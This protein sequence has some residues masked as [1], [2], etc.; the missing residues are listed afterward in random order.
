MIDHSDRN[1]GVGSMDYPGETYIA[2]APDGLQISAYR[3]GPNYGVPVLLIGG[4][5]S[6]MQ[7]VFVSERELDEIS[8]RLFSF[9]RRGYGKT[10]YTPDGYVEDVV[11]DAVA[12]LEGVQKFG[13]VA[14][15]GGVRS[16]LMISATL[17]ERVSGMVLMGGAAPPDLDIDPLEG[18]SDQ[19]KI[20]LT[21]AAQ[22]PEAAER[23]M[24]ARAR[25][26]SEDAGYWYDEVLSPSFRRADMASGVVCGLRSRTIRGHATSLGDG[27]GWLNDLLMGQKP[28]MRQGQLDLAG[29]TAPT[30]LLHG[31]ED[32][33]VSSEN[34]KLL[35]E[36]IPNAI[37]HILEGESHM[38]LPSYTYWSLET[39]RDLH[40]GSVASRA[41][42][43]AEQKWKEMRESFMQMNPEPFLWR[44][45]S[46]SFRE[47][48]FITK[49]FG[50][51]Y[52][53]ESNQG[54][55]IG[56]TFFGCIALI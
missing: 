49:L 27:S 3:M 40:L 39:V 43:L 23:D 51:Y 20:D 1:F 22:D 37:L 54:R 42:D 26:I 30:V 9:D 48:R 2:T 47:N 46:E 12:V 5:P 38:N 11:G 41:A 4:Q 31:S 16:A 15:S 53:E 21:N 55:I 32:P 34:S 7:E 6:S 33:F 18:V 52:R 35:A 28:W 8:V 24:Q 29:I 25:K 17:G 36:H 44:V 45:W 10:S 13:I 19:N 50:E 14:R 56:R